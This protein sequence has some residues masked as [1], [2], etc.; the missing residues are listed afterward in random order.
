MFL[1]AFNVLG[2]LS[3]PRQHRP[4]TA[5]IAVAA[6]VQLGLVRFNF[7]ATD[8]LTGREPELRHAV[9]IPKM[10]RPPF[11]DCVADANSLFDYTC[12]KSGGGY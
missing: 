4:T 12:E 6:F 7:G 2:V 10:A 3:A 11:A 5:T 9:T 1:V 8:A